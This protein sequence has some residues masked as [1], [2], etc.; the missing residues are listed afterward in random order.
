VD[1]E[2]ISGCL[3]RNTKHFSNVLIVMFFS[4][5][6]IV[7]IGTASK[8]PNYWTKWDAEIGLFTFASALFCFTAA[9]AALAC[10]PIAKRARRAGV[11][12]VRRP[13]VWI[14]TALAF[15]LASYD[16][17]GMIHERLGTFLSA[18]AP[19]VRKFPIAHPSDILKA[20]YVFGS[21]VF[22]WFLV[23][24]LRSVPRALKFYIAGVVFFAFEVF[25]DGYP[26][27]WIVSRVIPA[28]SD[29]LAKLVAGSCFT[30]A[31]ATYAM[32]RIGALAVSW[33][34]TEEAAQS[35]LGPANK[36]LIHNQPKQT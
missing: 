8:G 3:A 20:G 12:A 34:K 11:A 10:Y 28:G 30:I 6:A 7:A 36:V 18:S 21:L 35:E 9:A 15:A 26:N 33:L 23:Q 29:D 5:V 14:P 27:L 1:Y 31:F 32:D 22:T 13:W 25:V 19:W 24:E 2:R 16:E 4:A 17:W